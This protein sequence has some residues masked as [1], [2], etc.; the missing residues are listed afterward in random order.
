VDKQFLEN[1]PTGGDKQQATKIYPE[2]SM[3][4]FQVPGFE[5]PSKNVHDW[6]LEQINWKCHSPKNSHPSVVHR[7]KRGH[8]KLIQA[9][10]KPSKQRRE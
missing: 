10:D 7:V 3:R 1:Q 4:H 2:P 5:T 8:W 9:P 6:Q